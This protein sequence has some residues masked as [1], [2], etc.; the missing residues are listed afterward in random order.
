MV[1]H[2]PFV[3]EDLK[4]VVVFKEVE[5]KAS[6]SP[7]F[8]KWQTIKSSMLKRGCKM[9]LAQ[10]LVRDFFPCSRSRDHSTLPRISW[11]SAISEWLQVRREV[12]GP[13]NPFRSLP[14]KGST[15]RSK[16]EYWYPRCNAEYLLQQISTPKSCSDEHYALKIQIRIATMI[17]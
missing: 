7:K 8:L 10:I 2:F 4:D 11:N 5:R 14:S 13:A 1:G 3:Y 9:G 16:S 12:L 6:Q 17:A 15:C